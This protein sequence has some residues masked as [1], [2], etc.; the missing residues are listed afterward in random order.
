MSETNQKE[1]KLITNTPTTPEGNDAVI[2]LKSFNGN[3]RFIVTTKLTGRCCCYNCAIF[4]LEIILFSIL[5][6]TGIK[7][8]I[9]ILAFIIIF[10]IQCF[11]TIMV[12]KKII[13]QTELIK[14]IQNN[15]FEIKFLNY[16]SEPL[17]I[18]IISLNNVYF[19]PVSYSTK[20]EEEGISYTYGLIIVNTSINKSTIDLDKS[21]IKKPKKIAYLLDDVLS[22]NELY[23]FVGCEQKQNNQIFINVQE[24]MGIN[25]KENFS[26][27]K[28]KYNI[29]IYLKIS[30]N[31]F[32]FYLETHKINTCALVYTEICSVIVSFIIISI[33]F[34][35]N[36][37]MYIKIIVL[38]SFIIVF[39]LINLLYVCH[40]INHR[41]KDIKRIDI[42][43]SI[44]FDKVFFGL[45]NYNEEEYLDT[46][47][48]DKISIGYFYDTDDKKLIVQFKDGKFQTIIKF[49]DKEPLS[50]IKGIIFI[51]KKKFMNK[52]EKNTN[53]DNLLVKNWE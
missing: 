49:N 32:S 10:L 8:Y 24:Y 4:L 2:P 14:N 28:Y 3:Q 29:D 20:S 5:F 39:I 18:D 7:I 16:C 51:L 35:N 44:N 52:D 38:I 34:A 13:N 53:N 45:V 12:K 26:E 21:E 46:F 17:Y 22:F 48:F 42:V 33:I 11:V 25:Y 30:E 1:D 40:L 50:S 36:F 47:L 43:F 41:N 19:Q 9:K 37:D 6:A 27:K 23:N 15:T 31:F